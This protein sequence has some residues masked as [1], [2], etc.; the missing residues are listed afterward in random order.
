MLN[1]TVLLQDVIA[2]DNRLFEA[3]DVMLGP[4]A[5]LA[6]VVT[7]LDIELAKLANLVGWS[8]VYD[9]GEKPA[10]TDL[11]GQYTKVLHAALLMAARKQWT[12]LVVLDDQAFTRLLAVKPATKVADLNKEYLAIKNFTL[13][14][15]FSHRQEDFRHAWHLLLKLGLVDLG[16]SADQ[17][18]SAHQQLIQRAERT[19]AKTN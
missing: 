9:E 15:Y 16:V 12:H 8:R 13:G 18:M 1:I 14:S 3:K 4:E 6:N 19:I 7:T 11:A 17:I 5:R 10:A 2:T